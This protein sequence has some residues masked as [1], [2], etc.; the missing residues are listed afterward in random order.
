MPEGRI[1]EEHKRVVTECGADAVNTAARSAVFLRFVFDRAHRAAS[2]QWD[3]RSD[4]PGFVV[5]RLQ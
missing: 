1:S 2:P 4:E 3:I 5:P